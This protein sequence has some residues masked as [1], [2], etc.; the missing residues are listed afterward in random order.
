SAPAAS[1]NPWLS[2]T[3]IGS[4]ENAS[5]PLILCPTWKHTHSSVS[6]HRGFWLQ[7]A[8]DSIPRFNHP[9]FTFI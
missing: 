4:N 1:S 6:A 2:I 9:L 8:K 5:P 3:S 7:G